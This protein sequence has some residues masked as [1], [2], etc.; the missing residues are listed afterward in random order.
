MSCDDA[1]RIWAWAPILVFCALPVSLLCRCE[2]VARERLV[3]VKLLQSCVVLL[4]R[5]ATAKVSIC[6][7]GEVHVFTV[8]KYRWAVSTLLFS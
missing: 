4:R 8:F 7:A 5:M 2:V 6:L 1:V 3:E